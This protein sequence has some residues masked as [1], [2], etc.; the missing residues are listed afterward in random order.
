MTQ[1]FTPAEWA[2]PRKWLKTPEGISDDRNIDPLRRYLRI[3]LT[4]ILN[5]VHFLLQNYRHYV[6]QAMELYN[7][8]GL[9]AI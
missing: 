5:S 2:K 4:G 1:A 3:G 6:G 7:D 8:V 9:I